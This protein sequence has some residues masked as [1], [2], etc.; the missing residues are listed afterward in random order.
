MVREGNEKREGG[1]NDEKRAKRKREKERKDRIR[2]G[3]GQEGW[4]E[5]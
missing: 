3:D 2:G 5:G 1:I 4:G